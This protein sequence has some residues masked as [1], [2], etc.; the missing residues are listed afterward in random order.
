MARRIVAGL[1]SD[2]LARHL[3]RADLIQAVAYG[4]I[5]WLYPFQNPDG[6]WRANW[7]IGAALCLIFW[8]TN[9]PARAERFLRTWADEVIA[10]RGGMR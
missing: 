9:A 4:L 5:W 10:S 1:S 6:F 2:R 7:G 8:L 3:R